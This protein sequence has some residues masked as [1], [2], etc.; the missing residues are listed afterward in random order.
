M[1][2]TA[3]DDRGGWRGRMVRYGVAALLVV[4]V[5]L[6]AGWPLLGEEGRQ[7]LGLAAGI[8]LPA[9][10]VSFAVLATRRIGSPGLLLVWGSSTLLRFGVI[11]ISAFVLVGMEGVDLAV[12]LLAM[13]GLFFVLLL[14]EPWALRER[15]RKPMQP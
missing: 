1:E 4:A 3:V 11:G 10:L 2:R 6:A 14:L 13:A 8:V 12:A 7:G 15:D 9:Q 5:V